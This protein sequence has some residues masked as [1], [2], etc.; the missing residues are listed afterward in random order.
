MYVAHQSWG[1]GKVDG[2]VQQSVQLFM[3]SAQR[4]PAE[5]GN[6]GSSR[7]AQAWR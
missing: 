7:D 2:S 5:K 3:C 6:M 4:W 1:E